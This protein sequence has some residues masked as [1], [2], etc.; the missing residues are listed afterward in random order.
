MLSGTEQKI[1]ERKRYQVKRR[2]E[3]KRDVIRK[4]EEKRMRRK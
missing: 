3:K 1:Q 2:K 4:R